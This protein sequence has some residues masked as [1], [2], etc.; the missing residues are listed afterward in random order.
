MDLPLA[1][2]RERI[3]TRGIEE[4]ESLSQGKVRSAEKWKTSTE[5]DASHGV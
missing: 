2:E 4:V 5:E 1:S 3:M